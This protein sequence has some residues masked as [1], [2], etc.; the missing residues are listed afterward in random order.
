MQALILAGGRGK[1]MGELA[2]TMNKCLIEING[3]P[4]IAS[5]LDC[6][7]RLD[8]SE[9]II[10]VGYQAEDIKEYCKGEYNGKPIKYAFQSEQKGLVHAIESA[11]EA[12]RE[13]DFFL[14][15]GDEL[16]INPKHLEMLKKF[17]EEKLFAVCGMIKVDNPSLI[18]RT[19]GIREKGGLISELI[20]KPDIRD[21]QK[22]LV[23]KDAMGTGNCIF[24]N[25]IFSYIDKAPINPKRGEK[26][27]PDLIKAAIKDGKK[28]KSSLICDMYFNVNLRQDDSYFAHF[29]E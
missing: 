19:Y 24:Q 2:Q 13:D 29:S 22:G 14:F 5:S 9:I 18:S 7:S 12:I 28:V 26:E 15:L 16:M 23:S 11:R 1:R 21:I 20:E 4:L 27:L 3:R 10:V 25:A 8:V 6:A 17:Q